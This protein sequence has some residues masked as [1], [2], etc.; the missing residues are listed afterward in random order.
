M[1]DL[2]DLLLRFDN[3]VRILYPR[4]HG[5]DH[6]EPRTA[7]EATQGQ[8]LSQSPTEKPPDSGGICMGVD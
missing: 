5:L 8:I 2:R 7:L 4:E 6:A 3:R 1:K